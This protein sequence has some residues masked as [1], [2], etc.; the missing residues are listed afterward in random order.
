M[1]KVTRSC[2]VCGNRQERVHSERGVDHIAEVFI[3]TTDSSCTHEITVEWGDP[4]VTGARD[5]DG[6]EIEVDAAI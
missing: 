2:P 5:E 4:L 6:N 1:S 3:P